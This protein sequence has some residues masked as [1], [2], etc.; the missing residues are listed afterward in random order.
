VAATTL[1]VEDERDIADLVRY[2][3]EKT[4]DALPEVGGGGLGLP[5][6]EHLARARG[7]ES[8]SRARSAAARR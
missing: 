6:V 4:A 5:L 7:S 2:H 1:L 8:T 3:V